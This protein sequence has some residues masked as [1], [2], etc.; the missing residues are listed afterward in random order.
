MSAQSAARLEC[1][2]N[3]AG[4]T[5]IGQ[6]IGRYRI[7]AELGRGGMGV[8]YRAT[9]TN[10]GR[11]VAIK[12]L[13]PQ[14]AESG[15]HL[16]RFRR[17][18]EVLARLQ[19]ENIVHIYDVEEV[20]GAFCIIMEFVAGP[21]L[22]AVLARAG[23]LPPAVVRDIAVQLTA[24]LEA[25]HRKGIVHRDL[26]PDNIL[27]TPEGRPRITDFG[28]ARIAGG[29]AMSRTR[30]GVLMGTPY[31]M[32]PEQ[33]RGGEITGSSDQYSLGVL[34]YQM[35][36]GSVPFHGHDPIS[37]AIKHMQE[38][39]P[40]LATTVPGLPGAL[41]AVVGRALEKDP[42]R[43]FPSA[44]SMGEALRKLELTPASL[45][46]FAVGEH[47]SSSSD[48]VI[49]PEC[50]FRVHAAFVTCP[51][52]AL[53][54]REAGA[55]VVV[56]PAAET[57]ASASA[58]P[59]IAHPA[60]SPAP[61]RDAEVSLVVAG[62]AASA[63]RVMVDAWPV[64]WP[65]W[66]RPRG[67]LGIPPIMVAGA[68]IV[69][70]GVTVGFLSGS[71]PRG[72]F[73]VGDGGVS[74][75]AATGVVGSA[76]GG[77]T[78]AR[79]PGIALPAGGLLPRGTAGTPPADAGGRGGSAP[80]PPPVADAGD[81]SVA[82]SPARPSADARSNR[83]A[84]GDGSAADR[85]SNTTPAQPERVAADP[86]PDVATTG[87]ENLPPNFDIERARRELVAIAER[88]R[89]ATEAGD[90]DLFVGDLSPELA[91]GAAPD[92]AALHREWSAISSEIWNLAI[93][94]EDATRARM[95]FH[96]RISGEPARRGARRVIQDVHVYWTLAHRG[97]R[98]V[99]IAASSGT[100]EDV[101]P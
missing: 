18:A 97:G 36:S 99:I 87:R 72:A 76:T 37:L 62:A 67:R 21:S 50:S 94:F 33:A 26:K 9:Q 74:V 31:Y 77:N 13:S 4:Q 47:D 52:C 86:M 43:R 16:A 34:L 38:P 40:P 59:A 3:E 79:A 101:N 32:S 55:G 64:D 28:I 90:A 75:P 25:A 66:I 95:D 35:L 84:D 85:A 44:A 70:L 96:T 42:H 71:P 93:Y 73:A 56:G 81:G 91:R 1:S 22:G 10:L 88:Q 82:D 58:P 65:D 12:M 8:V 5:M 11:T 61:R 6:T 45:P 19:H 2:F 29:D 7:D 46:D 89:R 53:P 20:G 39:V 54:L 17:E 49:C 23:A 15:E 69:A 78:G 80:T 14:L 41:V 68:G 27:F 83:G 48:D 30:T 100:H 63:W 98:W 92:L 60:P 57:H 24:G 51:R